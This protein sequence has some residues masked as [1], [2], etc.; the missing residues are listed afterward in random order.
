MRENRIQ[1][2]QVIR[3]KLQRRGGLRLNQR[4]FAPLVGF[5]ASAN[6]LFA[7]I[8]AAQLLGW[9]IPQEKSDNPAPAAAKI[10]NPA[11]IREQS[12]ICFVVLLEKLVGV[13]PF[14]Q[15]REGRG[16]CVVFLHRWRGKPRQETSYFRATL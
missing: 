14:L 15:S 8:G 13:K 12:D 9:H 2:N 5:P 10:Q 3:L 6:G 4:E 16:A 7:V 1:I 11:T